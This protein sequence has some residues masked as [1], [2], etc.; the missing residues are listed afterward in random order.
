V[1]EGEQGQLLER[2]EELELAAGVATRRAATAEAELDM[3]KQQL[4]AA[5]RKTKEL[6]WQVRGL[7]DMCLRVLALISYH[8]I[9][10][11]L[12]VYTSHHKTFQV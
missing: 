9:S 3:L 7:L 6:A 2:M 5:D 11:W 4:E 8:C 10:G 12:N 1:A